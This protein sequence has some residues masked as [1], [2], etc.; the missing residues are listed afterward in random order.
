MPRRFPL[1]PLLD[2]AQNHTDA[3][4]RN[5]HALKVAWQGAEEKHRQ[6]ISYRGDYQARLLQATKMGMQV[7]SLKDFQLF[8]G[9]L[10]AA[11]RQQAEEVERCKKRWEEG[12]HEWQAK[13]RKL[14]AFD[15][16]SLRHQNS[17]KKREDKLEQRE[18]DE[19]SGKKFEQE[20]PK[21]QTHS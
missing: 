5:L 21:D 6:L 20:E 3:A 7:N 4:A 13:Q 17:E 12:R 10:E 19:L 9:K 15:T 18:Q 11:I 16:L 1:Q 2:L 14:K 8:L